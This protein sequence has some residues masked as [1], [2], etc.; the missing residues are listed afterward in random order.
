MF[1]I[2][3]ANPCYTKVKL[4][5]GNISFGENIIVQI[6]ISRVL[7]FRTSSHFLYTLMMLPGLSADGP[8]RHSDGGGGPLL[9]A[10]L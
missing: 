3:L 8:R 4:D 6:I 9:S 7:G 5:P 2:F 1:F 10:P